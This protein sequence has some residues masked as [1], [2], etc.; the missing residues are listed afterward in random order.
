LG[1]YDALN[2]YIQHQAGALFVV[3]PGLAAGEDWG[4]QLFG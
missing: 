3:P 4:S 2:E 1:Q